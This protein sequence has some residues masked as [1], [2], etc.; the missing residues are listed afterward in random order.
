MHDII[1]SIDS[2]ISHYV[3]SSGSTLYTSSHVPND[4][5]VDSY[6]LEALNE[7]GKDNIF[8]ATYSLYR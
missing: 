4:E 7:W 3:I 1:N 6:G 2:E 8:I 5:R